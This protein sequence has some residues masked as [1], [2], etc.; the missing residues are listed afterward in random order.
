MVTVC[1]MHTLRGHENWAISP[2]PVPGGGVG[3][4]I[5]RN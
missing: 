1:P 3:V 5:A 4:M 2:M